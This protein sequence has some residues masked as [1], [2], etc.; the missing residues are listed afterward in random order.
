MSG[1]RLAILLPAG[2]ASATPHL[3]SIPLPKVG[4]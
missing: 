4:R 1:Q 3:E 2:I